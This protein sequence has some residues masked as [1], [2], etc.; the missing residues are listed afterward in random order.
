VPT[1]LACV[2]VT[3]ASRPS[4]AAAAGLRRAKEE[5]FALLDM[6]TDST[7][8][9]LELHVAN[10]T[11]AEVTKDA[12]FRPA[13]AIAV[14]FTRRPN[15]EK[16][17]R[18]CGRGADAALLLTVINGVDV[19]PSVVVVPLQKRTPGSL[20]HPAPPCASSVAAGGLSPPP[21]SGHPDAQ[22]TI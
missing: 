17:Y 14:L 5:V 8:A 11:F 12:I 9:P 4:P 15:K 21:M 2:R 10:L 22:W 13:V 7:I 20:C 18:M 1:P 19:T 16:N 6:I 3:A